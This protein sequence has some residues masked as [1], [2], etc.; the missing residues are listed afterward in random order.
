M[1]SESVRPEFVVKGGEGK[2]AGA[3]GMQRSVVGDK[4]DYSLA[5]DGVMFRRWAEHLTR[6]TRPPANYAKR[7]WLLALNGTPEERQDA[8]DRARESAVRHF[9]QWYLGN[10]DEDHAAAVFFNVNVDETLKECK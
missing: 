2:T 1:S 8:R 6:A 10:H 7:N 4:T 3:G 9:I 5:L